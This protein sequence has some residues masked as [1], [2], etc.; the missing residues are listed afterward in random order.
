M[1]GESGSESRAGPVSGGHLA[2]LLRGPRSESRSRCG[3]GLRVRDRIG[4]CS[5]LKIGILSR[6]AESTSRLLH[7]GSESGVG[8]R[9]WSPPHGLRR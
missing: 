1:G 4:V 3:S 5:R 2:V 7:V 6:V 9:D 8:V